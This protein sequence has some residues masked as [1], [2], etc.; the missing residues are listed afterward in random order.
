MLQKEQ[1]LHTQ[2]NNQEY[3]ETHG[4]SQTIQGIRSYGQ[5]AEEANTQD[6]AVSQEMDSK[7]S[8]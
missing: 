7:R 1:K 2:A 5:G 3:Q 8:R 6:L 4:T